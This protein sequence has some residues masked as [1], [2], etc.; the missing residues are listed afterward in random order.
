M[1]L[2]R[3]KARGS[4]ACAASQAQ[5]SASFAITAWGRKEFPCFRGWNL[6]IAHAQAPERLTKGVARHPIPLMLLARLAV[7]RE[8]QGRKIGAGLL[9]DAMVRT[10]QAA[11]ILG[12]R[13]LAVH[14]KDDKAVA[15]YTRFG[16]I[17]SPI[18][19]WQMYLLLKDIRR[20]LGRR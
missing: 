5:S 18:N 1:S 2:P 20:L 16:F 12:I 9:R 10:L 3:S 19:P 15:F 17:P 14:A 4:R 8:W 13:A 11:E 7:H 6:E